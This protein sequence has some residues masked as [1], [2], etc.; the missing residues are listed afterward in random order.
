MSGSPFSSARRYAIVFGAAVLAVAIAAPAVATPALADDAVPEKIKDK[1]QV[2]NSCHGAKGA[3]M[4]A[5]TP[6]IWGQQQNYLVKQIHDYRAKDRNNP[7][8]SAIAGGVTQEDTRPLAAYFAAQPW[9]ATPGANPSA[10][11]PD[12]IAAKLGQCQACHQKN[13]E[14]GA[15]APRLAGL[16]YQYLAAS[17]K[18]FA[19]GTRTNNLD[20]PKIM[21]ALT[22]TERDAMAKYLAGL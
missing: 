21:Q 10:P 14:G 6:V 17:M 1:V 16:S 3:P 15:P 4:S 8:M 18:A 12:S 5:T 19:D 2:C 9:P 20:M 7:I 22:E 11:P 13:F